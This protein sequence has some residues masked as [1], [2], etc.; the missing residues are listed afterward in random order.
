METI[1]KMILLV[2]ILKDISAVIILVYSMSKL[3]LVI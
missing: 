1:S 2:Q 3:I